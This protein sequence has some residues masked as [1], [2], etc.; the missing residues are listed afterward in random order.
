MAG[1]IRLFEK[2]ERG[3][4]HEV[5]PEDAEQ[6]RHGRLVSHMN[7]GIDVLWTVDEETARGAEE[8]ADVA[9]DPLVEQE[10]AAK[11]ATDKLRGLGLTADEIDVRCDLRRTVEFQ[12]LDGDL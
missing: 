7:I 4:L 1:L 9:R 2:D 11:A 3:L 12:Y 8:Q 6:R 5:A 10:R